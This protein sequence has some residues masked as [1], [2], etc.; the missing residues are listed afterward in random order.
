MAND[1]VQSLEV[2]LFAQP[3]GPNTETRYLGCHTLASA[4][5][6]RGNNTL[7]Y[8]PHPTQPRQYV[9]SSKTK[10]PPGLV[11]FTVETKMR[12]L[13]DYL[14]ELKC[15]IPL[16]ANVTSCSPK[17]LFSNWD[18]SFIFQNADVV[19]ET[20]NNLVSGGAD[21]NE[22]MQAFDMEADDIIRVVPLRVTRDSSIAETVALNNLFAC[23]VDMCPGVCGA[24]N[25]R[26][27]TFYAVA[28]AVV[29]SASAKGSLWINSDGV[30][31]AAASDPFD[32]GD[33]IIAGACFQL[34][35]TTRRILVFRGSTDAGAPAEA[36]YT[37]DNGATWTR[38]NIGSDNG[39]YVISPK[40]LA[41]VDQNNIWVGTDS[42]RIYFS[43]NGGSSWSV[44]ED[45]GIHASA[46][47]WVSALDDRTLFAGGAGDVIAVSIDGGEVWSQTN[48]T[49][50]GGDII[51]G[52]IIDANTFWVGTDDG[53]LFYT[54]DAGVNWG[55]RD[56]EGA[57]SGRIDDMVFN[58]NM[59]GFMSHRNGSNQ[60][61]FFQ[62]RNG[63]WTW[64]QIVT[65]T[66]SGLNSIL[67]CGNNRVWA[68]GEANGGRPVVYKLQ[69]S[70]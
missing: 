17:N 37:D 10:A 58:N 29:G 8:C 41:V 31:T 52:G 54:S 22:V 62:T 14:E 32:T 13:M 45:Q 9:V 40:A 11:T 64:E 60:S 21:N 63:G 16:I 3:R 49:G 24:A 5:R 69:P 42:G 15:P 44:Q 36:A 48:A 12:R 28:D 47:N 23:D 68:V 67:V 6:P 66:N 19:Q 7:N 18:R 20:L 4:T 2:A 1:V 38:V 46:W 30:W 50:E 70:A 26:C 65:P 39:E 43:N 51:S 53:E 59:V 56:F 33:H 57:G 34:S 55:K 61:T 27:D 25:E 35:R